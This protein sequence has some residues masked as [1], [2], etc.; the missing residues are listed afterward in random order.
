MQD[1]ETKD[2]LKGANLI[3]LLRNSKRNIKIPRA[4]QEETRR[5]NMGLMDYI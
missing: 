5:G 1:S 2:K 4:G 3:L